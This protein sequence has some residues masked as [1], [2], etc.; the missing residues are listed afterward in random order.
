MFWRHEVLH[1]EILK[2]YA[3]RIIPL[4]QERDAVETKFLIESQQVRQ[5]S[6]EKKKYFHRNVLLKSMPA[7]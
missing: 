1:R 3:A 2:D 5:A 4:T 7:K 6:A